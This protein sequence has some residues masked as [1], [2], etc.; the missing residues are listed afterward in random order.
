MHANEARKYFHNTLYICGRFYA[1]KIGY[2]TKYA[3]LCNDIMSKTPLQTS[4]FICFNVVVSIHERP[5]IVFVFLLHVI[6]ICKAWPY[7]IQQA[8]KEKGS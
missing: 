3:K 2:K 6:N 8:I 5:L 1:E 4:H 7:G